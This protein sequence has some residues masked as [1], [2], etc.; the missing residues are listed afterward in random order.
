MRVRWQCDF[1]R[2][3]ETAP[4]NYYLVGLEQGQFDVWRRD[5][6]A[7]AFHQLREQL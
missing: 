1:S 3:R 2:H 6:T 7:V 5:F 4:R